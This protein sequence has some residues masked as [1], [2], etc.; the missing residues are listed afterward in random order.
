MTSDTLCSTVIYVSY[1]FEVDDGRIDSSFEWERKVA[2]L[3]G[4]GRY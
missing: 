2:A 1:E 4:T 3:T